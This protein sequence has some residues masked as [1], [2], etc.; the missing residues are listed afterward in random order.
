LG[1]RTGE[2]GAPPT[3]SD[4]G[5]IIGGDLCRVPIKGNRLSRVEESA[6]DVVGPVTLCKGSHLRKVHNA[7]A[8]SGPRTTAR[9]SEG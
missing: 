8:P 9:R 6:T 3:S 5:A 2:H 7:S 4:R 1:W